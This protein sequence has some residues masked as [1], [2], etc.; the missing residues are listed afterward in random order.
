MK[1]KILTF[2]GLMLLSSMTAQERL[3]LF[4]LAGSYG[5]PTAYDSIYQGKGTETGVM[6]SL[7]IPAV[8]SEKRTGPSN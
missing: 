4:T 6:A 3:A 2:L 8:L 5:F 7:V 1:I